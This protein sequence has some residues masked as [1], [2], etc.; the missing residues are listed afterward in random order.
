[1]HRIPRVEDRRGCK[2]LPSRSC[3]VSE[4]W[5]PTD[6]SCWL[7]AVLFVFLDVPLR[8]EVLESRRA[9]LPGQILVELVL[10]GVQTVA[11][12]GAGAELGDVEAGSVGHVDHERV[13]EDHQVVLLQRRRTSG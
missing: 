4:L 13:G 1:M 9:V 6:G 7:S 10:Q 2:A 12:A 3:S 5:S 8:R 11:I